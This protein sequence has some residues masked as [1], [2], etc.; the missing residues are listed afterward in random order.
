VTSHAVFGIR[1]HGP[2]SAR[3]LVAALREYAPDVVLIEGPPDAAEVLPLAGHEAMR[4]P[5]ALLVYRPDEPKQSVFYPFTHYSPEW[6]AIGFAL[7]HDIPARF[8][9]LPVALRFALDAE[10]RAAEGDEPPAQLATDEI[11]ES[12]FV[13]LARAA[14]YSDPD[15]WWERVIEQRRD[16]SDVFAAISEAMSALR[17]EAPEPERSEQMREAHMRQ[18]IRAAR[19]EGFE[20]IA[21][22]CGAWHVPAL[23]ELG[24]VK[25]DTDL[26]KGM[27]KVKV[28]ATWIPWTNSR[29]SYRSGYGAGVR[30]PGWHAHLWAATN[31][32]YAPGWVARAARLLRDEGLDAPS[33]N[34]IEAVR[35]AETLAALRDL[36]SP[37]LD[38]LNE[39][40]LTALCHGNIAPMQLIRDKLEI[41][42]ALGEVPPDAPAV[43]LQADL[44]AQQ[45]RLR[46]KPSTEQRLLDLDLRNETDRERSR[47]LHRLRAL[48]IEWGTREHASGKGTFREAWKIQWKPELAVSVIDAAR[49]GNTVESAAVGRLRSS[50]DTAERLPQLTSLLNIAIYAALPEAVNHILHRI[51]DVSAVA[52]DV[53]QML[54]ALPPL[55]QVARYGDVRETDREQVL[56]VID[57]IFERAIVGLPVA[58]ASLDDDAA[59]SMA[60]SIGRG[61]ESVILLDRPEQRAEWQTALRGISEREGVH[62]LVRGWCCRLLLEEGV[63]DSAEL[64]R[65]A[66][67]SLSPATP[68]SEA[69]AWIEGVTRGSGLALLHQDGLWLAIDGWLQE[70][71]GDLFTATLPLLR[72]AFSG[73]SGPER[74]AMGEKA[75]TLGS[76]S[77][78]TSDGD[79]LE[80]LD[81]ERADLVLP[82]LSQILGVVIEGRESGLENRGHQAEPSPPPFPNPESRFP[83]HEVPHGN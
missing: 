29:L 18:M 49:W 58:C 46:L 26:L 73:F 17:E 15:L 30:S 3:G 65:L 20:R 71:D 59:V 14:G 45:K 51:R 4:P 9:D 27:K 37:G 61:H 70:L 34:V 31:D 44:A 68:T 50:A 40:I 39:A 78:A 82:V 72:R 13:A 53:R 43:P 28:E 8:I 6:Q 67:L 16:A 62:G 75:R 56:P 21:V 32:D 12:P 52:T 79:G 5:V 24:P 1:H 57:A 54:D 7:A 77:Q 48:Y 19:R 63:L 35:L 81:T 76:P 10:E 60:E 80:Q 55:A 64:S 69:A 22:V 33:S 41:G 66:R 11:R 38:E 23:A 36:A 42:D 25:P 2:G 74:R 83:N 47:L